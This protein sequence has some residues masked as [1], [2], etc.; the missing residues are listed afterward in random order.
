MLAS[1]KDP[2][3]A[4]EKAIWEAYQK[5]AEGNVYERPPMVFE[6]PLEGQPPIMTHVYEG[7]DN[8]IIAAKGAAERIISICKLD[9]ETANKIL[10]KIRSFAAQGY[11]VIGVA[12][13]VYYE[14][15][16][17]SSSG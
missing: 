15:R 3:D 9:N 1:E 5:H 4:M 16:I 14:K 6:Y 2:F 7:K 12:S 11:R 13:S 10:K 8:K 17:A